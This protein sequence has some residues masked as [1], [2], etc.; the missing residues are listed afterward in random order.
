MD[1]LFFMIKG[2]Q[3]FS[4]DKHFW[5]KISDVFEKKERENNHFIWAAH[6]LSL[7]SKSFHSTAFTKTDIYYKEKNFLC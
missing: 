3:K 1:E 2:P 7:R 5:A 4:T 6:A